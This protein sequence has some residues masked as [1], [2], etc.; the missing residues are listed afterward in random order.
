MDADSIAKKIIQIYE[1][2]VVDFQSY[3]KNKKIDFKKNST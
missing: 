3:N 1:D 2:N